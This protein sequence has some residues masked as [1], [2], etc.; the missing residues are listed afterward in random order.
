[1]IETVLHDFT[2]ARDWIGVPSDLTASRLTKLCVDVP[3]LA[4]GVIGQHPLSFV[5][6]KTPVTPTRIQPNDVIFASYLYADPI[7]PDC[8]IL[9]LTQAHGRAG[10]EHMGLLAF[11][12]AF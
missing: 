4:V 2:L 12:L 8:R 3:A 5:V 9:T 10:A 6:Q 7:G 1:M 11:F